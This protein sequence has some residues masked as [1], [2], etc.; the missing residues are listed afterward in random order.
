MGTTRGPRRSTAVALVVAIGVAA[1]AGFLISR[2]QSHGHET[3]P[4]STPGP[5]VDAPFSTDGYSVAGDPDRNQL[6]VFGGDLE[7]QP[8]MA[9]GNALDARAPGD[10]PI[11]TRECGDRV[12]P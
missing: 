12:R 2:P 3:A 8:D 5:N 6:V 7:S 11:R 1:V 9:V 10:Q 4:V